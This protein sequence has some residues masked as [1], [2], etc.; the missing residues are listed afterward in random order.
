M[1]SLYGRFGMH[2]DFFKYDIVDQKTLD[3]IAINFP[4]G[5]IVRLGDM[6]LVGYSTEE[7]GLNLSVSG[8]SQ[9]HLREVL[10]AR[11]AN[12]NVPIAA[13]V[14]S[15]SRMIINQYKLDSIKDGAT[16][17]YSDTD[18]LFVNKPLPDNKLSSTELGLMKLEHKIKEA[19][20]VMPKVYYLFDDNNKETTK[21]K[22]FSGKLSKDQYLDLYN[23]KPIELSVT[24]WVKNREAGEIFIHHGRKYTLNPTFNKRLKVFDDSGKWVTTSPLTLNE[25]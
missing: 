13:T 3:K 8:Q 5:N 12:I 6:F 16:L 17:Y 23:G 14:T 11:P 24:R 19:Y 7:G 25:N 9:K 1:N 21:C 20:F 18:S 4:I 10:K 2:P 15:Y 22:G